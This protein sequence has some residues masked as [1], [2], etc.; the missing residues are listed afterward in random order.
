MAI[1]GICKI[2]PGITRGTE[3]T[4]DT[5]MAKTCAFLLYDIHSS[6]TYFLTLYIA[7]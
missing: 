2:T 1:L 4:W 7:K 6:T 5:Y 3:S